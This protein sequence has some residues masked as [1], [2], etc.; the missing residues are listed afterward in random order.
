MNETL[1][2][3]AFI[4]ACAVM[5]VLTA[6]AMDGI[7]WIGETYPNAYSWWFTVSTTVFFIAILLEGIF[8]TLAP[9]Q[10]GLMMILFFPVIGHNLI[11][12]P[13]MKSQ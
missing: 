11:W 6:Y 1:T 9:W 8:L 13:L 3:F 12:D 4:L 10:L 5:V 7:T 2:F